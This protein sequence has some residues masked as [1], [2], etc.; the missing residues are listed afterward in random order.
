VK[1]SNQCR[2]LLNSLF[3]AEIVSQRNNRAQNRFVLIIVLWSNIINLAYYIVNNERKRERE[4]ERERERGVLKTH[5]KY[6]I[7]L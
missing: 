4:R 6:L 7:F 2:L 3:Y 1:I 5:R